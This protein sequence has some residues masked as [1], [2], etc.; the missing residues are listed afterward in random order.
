MKVSSSERLASIWVMAV[1]FALL[2]IGPAS[3][4]EAHSEQSAMEKI[5]APLPDQKACYHRLYDAHHLSE[6]PG[7]KISEMTFLLR[8]EGLDATGARV[9]KNPDHIVYQFAL[10]LR[11]RNDE[12]RLRTSGDC[13]GGKVAE[14]VVDCDGGGVTLENSSQ[15]GGLRV[16]LQGEGIAFGNDCDTTRGYFVGPGS[17]DKAFDLKPAPLTECQSLESR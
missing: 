3:A 1:N 5:L 2:G 9:L 13:V 12:R 8:V 6:H 11:R 14:C 15:T 17:D 10:S 16:L 4:V 7:Q